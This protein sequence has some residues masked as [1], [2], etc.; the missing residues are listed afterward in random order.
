[1]SDGQTAFDGHFPTLTDDEEFVA[2]EEQLAK[3]REAIAETSTA[4]T[5]TLPDPKEGAYRVGEIR[6]RLDA[7]ISLAKVSE[8]GQGKD[9]GGALGKS[10]RFGNRLEQRLSTMKSAVAKLDIDPVPSKFSPGALRSDRGK[11]FYGV[12]CMISCAIFVIVAFHSGW[13]L[14]P[15]PERVSGAGLDECRVIYETVIIA[16]VKRSSSSC[17]G[18]Y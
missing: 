10:V 14:W 6:K 9:A 5:T 4:I 17:G 18:E 3:L 7:M 12:A 16:K 8:T 2:V 13:Q 11:L 1:M 15:K